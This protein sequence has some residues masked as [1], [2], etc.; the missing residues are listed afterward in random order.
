MEC[1]KCKEKIPDKSLYCMHC[2]SPQKRDKKKK[3]YQR[4]DGL[5]E[6]VITKD[7]TRIPFRG[8]SE[9]EVNRKILEYSGNVEK[10]RLF[11]VVAKE[12][13]DEHF[14]GVEHNTI[15]GYE[16]AYNRSVKKFGSRR[17]KE[18]TTKDI[19]NYIN[20]FAAEG[21]AQKT[22]KNQLSVFHLI[23]KKA[24]KDGELD[25]N[26]A[27]NVDIP[28]NL[29]K[30]KRA[31]PTEEEIEVVKNSV[32]CT[33]GL[34]AYFLLYT[35]CRRGEALALQYKDVDRD[36][37][38]ISITK[39]VYHVK[40]KPHIKQPKTDAGTRD[41]ILI[42]KLLEVLPEGKK[43]DYIFSKN[44]SVP[45]TD[46]ECRRQW[47]LYQRETGLTITPHQLRHAYA[48]IL[49]EAGVDEKDAQE[50]LGHASIAMT[51]D[52]YTHISKKRK[53]KTAELLNKFDG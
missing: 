41:I 23:F 11:S 3:M 45:L 44:G 7:G 40:N 46:K 8:R 30:K 49:F 47:E 38:I 42:D 21:Y 35:G 43:G 22:V 17:T 29:P 36:K 31:I 34:F 32:N 50:L 27:D 28:K 1:K 24:I 33:F 12:W 4:P 6:K 26:P 37:K 20:E 16:A 9:S 19:S 5:F 52:V 13:K 39:S 14:A 18:I 25:Y 10:G 15:R 51:K 2:G 53:D 48:T